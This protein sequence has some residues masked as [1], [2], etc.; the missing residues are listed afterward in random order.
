MLLWRRKS[1]SILMIYLIL[2]LHL[3]NGYNIIGTTF[4]SGQYYLSWKLAM[5]E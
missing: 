2:C 1:V 4:T 5:V 3:F